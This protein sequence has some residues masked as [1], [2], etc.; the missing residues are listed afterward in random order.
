MNQLGNSDGHLYMVVLNLLSTCSI[1]ELEEKNNI[2]QKSH[3]LCTMEH[4][5]QL[6]E[7]GKELV[8]N[9]WLTPHLTIESIRKYM[10][11]CKQS[12]QR[13]NHGGDDEDTG[14]MSRQRV[15]NMVPMGIT[16]FMDTFSGSR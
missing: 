12:G 4:R 2:I 11:L 3:D 13:V 16:A 6:T 10:P 8:V 9:L 15:S 1:L 7:P 5:R 14:S